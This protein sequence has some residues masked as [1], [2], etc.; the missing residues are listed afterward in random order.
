MPSPHTVRGVLVAV[1]VALALAAPVAASEHDAATVVVTASFTSKTSLRVSTELLRF[2]VTD[3]G[4]AS[5]AVDFAAGARTRAGGEVV[6]T[7]EPVRALEGPGGAADVET[8]V[9]FDGVGEGTHSGALASAPSVAGRWSGS[10]LRTGR[11]QFS[12]HSN[13]AG[14]YTLPVRFVLSAP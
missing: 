6:L 5:V 13:V 9:S 11:L 8:A 7:V 2:E 1:T 12:L 14:T 3:S 10:G 4:A